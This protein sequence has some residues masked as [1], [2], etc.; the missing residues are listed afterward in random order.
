TAADSVQL[1]GTWV[2]FLSS[3]TVDSVSRIPGNGPWKNLY[4][5]TIFN[6]RAGFLT[7]P[8]TPIEYDERKDPTTIYNAFDQ[9]HYPV[10]VWTGSTHDGV[11]ATWNNGSSDESA[12][13]VD[14]TSAPSNGSVYYHVGNVGLSNSTSPSWI[15]GALNG[16]ENYEP[17]DATT[18]AHL[19]CFE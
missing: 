18:T 3:S 1:G 13:C 6:N 11:Q 19:Y 5:A 14:W 2:A 4:G 10:A 16:S 8:L 17:C 15:E 7:G 12:T 9:K